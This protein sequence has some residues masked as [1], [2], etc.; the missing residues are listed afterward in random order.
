MSSN[1]YIVAGRKVTAELPCCDEWRCKIT[2]DLDL[3]KKGKHRPKGKFRKL[4]GV[5]ELRT[6]TL[7]WGGLYPAHTARSL[8]QRGLSSHFAVGPEAIHQML[9]LN[10]EAFHAGF[11]NA[12]SIGIDIAQQVNAKREGY[13]LERGAIVSRIKNPLR[14][15]GDPKCILS[16]DPRT[17]RNTRQLVESLLATFDIPFRVPRRDGVFIRT[18]V[19]KGKLRLFRGVIGHFHVTAR[20]WDPLPWWPSVFPEGALSVQGTG[21]APP[22]NIS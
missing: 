15:P 12:H 20:R 3:A 19:K 14:R 13:Y 18:R 6:V 10:F 21:D 11:N 22:D 4:K 9:D 1:Y 17:A 5:R 16:L 8:A 2:H 7:H